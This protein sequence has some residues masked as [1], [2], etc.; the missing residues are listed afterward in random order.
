M[1]SLMQAIRR[2]L[3][4]AV[5]GYGWRLGALAAVATVAAL[6]KLL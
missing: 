2:V 6:R 4:Y 3:G 1:A 5:K